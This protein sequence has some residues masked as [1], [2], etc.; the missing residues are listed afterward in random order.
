MAGTRQISGAFWRARSSGKPMVHLTG[1][2]VA[3]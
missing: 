3:F 2:Q 1:R